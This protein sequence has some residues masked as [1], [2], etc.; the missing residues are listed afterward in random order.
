LSASGFATAALACVII[1]R[2]APVLGLARVLKR[3]RFELVATAIAAAVLTQ[4]PIALIAATGLLASPIRV[5]IRKSLTG[6]TA[7][8]RAEA[9]VILLAFGGGGLLWWS[10]SRTAKGF[11]E[12]TD[13]G[14]ALAQPFEW[15]RR[16]V[17]AQDVIL[18][19]REYSAPLAALAGRRVLF[20]PPEGLAGGE[21]GIP[22]PS[23]RA[24]LF[25]S[26]LKGQ[27]VARLAEHFSAT[28][29]F[30]GPGEAT[31]ATGDFPP[32]EEPVM[33]LVPVYQDVKDF[34]VFRLTKK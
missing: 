3:F 26:T 1:S 14:T 32:S 33:T 24:R 6:P 10:P 30:L 27:P 18:A 20:P 31:P 9:L 15:I 19:S 13:P 28:H 7:V 5:A 17:P 12:A 34:R 11:L 2:L 8:R 25:T 22:E 4:S 23:R 29:L 21:T 16:N